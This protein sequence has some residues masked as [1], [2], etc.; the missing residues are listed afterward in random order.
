MSQS[1][2]SADSTVYSGPSY[3]DIEPKK[4]V[5]ENV[6]EFKATRDPESR[7]V[8]RILRENGLECYCR[9]HTNE[10]MMMAALEFL[11]CLQLNARGYLV[12]EVRG[13][14][15]M[16]MDKDISDCF[17]LPCP[18]N[19]ILPEFYYIGEERAILSEILC[20]VDSHIE[21]NLKK[22]LL[23][24]KYRLLLEIVQTVIC[25]IT[26]SK[27]GLL[28]QKIRILAALIDR[29]RNINWVQML[30]NKLL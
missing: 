7:E 24:R 9:D 27:D 22:G 29:A 13:E 4:I 21:T 20:P 16:L 26:S 28:A 2:S 25:G 8:L 3:P 6:V 18:V 19:G 23:K 15:I 14:R 1:S 11:Y 12:S 30:K 17:D 10:I 5:T